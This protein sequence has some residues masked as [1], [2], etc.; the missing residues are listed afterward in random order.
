MQSSTVEEFGTR[1]VRVRPLDA[2]V[3]VDGERW[4]GHEGIGE[5]WLELGAGFH[6]IEVS[7]ADHR[8]Y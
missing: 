7:R 6:S 2:I 5:L 3:T 8:S 1:L 4:V